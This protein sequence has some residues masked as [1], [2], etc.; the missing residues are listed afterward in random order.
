MTKREPRTDDAGEVR[1]IK[2]SDLK[3]A[4]GLHQLPDSMQAK[5][6]MRGPQKAPTKEQISI[7]LSPEV[8]DGF[9]ALGAGWQS[10]IDAALQEWLKDHRPA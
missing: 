4:L 3:G 5:L 9:R 2:A 10:R 1:E 6:R 7:R 8:L